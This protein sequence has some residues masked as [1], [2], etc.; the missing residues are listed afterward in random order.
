MASNL[1]SDEPDLYKQL[2]DTFKEEEKLKNRSKKSA[3]DVR[4]FL[5]A[6]M[7]L[8]YGLLATDEQGNVLPRAK[9]GKYLE[10]M[11]EEAWAHIGGYRF[12]G[13]GT[14]VE[15]TKKNILSQE[16]QEAYKADP[17]EEVI[18]QLMDYMA[19]PFGGR[20]TESWEGLSRRQMALRYQ[21]GKNLGI[22]AEGWDLMHKMYID[23]KVAPFIRG[24]GLFADSNQEFEDKTRT[25]VDTLAGQK[26]QAGASQD[27][28]QNAVVRSVGAAI[29]Y[30]DTVMNGISQLVQDTLPGE[31]NYDNLLKTLTKYDATASEIAEFVGPNKLMNMQTFEMLRKAAQ[32]AQKNLL[33]VVEKS[34][35]RFTKE[36]LEEGQN[37]TANAA[38]QAIEDNQQ[39][40]LS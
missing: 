28:N 40:K 7:D 8:A 24:L 27:P 23:E 15:T 39:R 13:R 25:L 11:V 34:V 19:R 38:E 35:P 2:Q 16:A 4:E 37:I 5:E 18:T 1:L 14:I 21:S 29:T 32:G 17:T 30:Q 36:L 22:G 20:Q 10:S 26:T 12:G 6:Q 3:Q 31:Q 33:D 9:R